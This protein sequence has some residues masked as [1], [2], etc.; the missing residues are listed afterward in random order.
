ML[1]DPLYALDPGPD[2]PERVRMI[3]EI[4]KH[5]SNKYEYDS[6][7][8]VFRLDRA[9]YSPMHYPGTLA[10]D[11]DPWTC[12]SWWTRT[13]RIRRFWRCRFPHHLREIEHLS[14]TPGPGG[15]RVSGAAPRAAAGTRPPPDGRPERPPQAEGLPHCKH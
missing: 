11:G 9:L 14:E 6:E 7:M 5:S 3:V 10:E 4:P 8:G 2:C 1:H 15:V 13:S 12:W